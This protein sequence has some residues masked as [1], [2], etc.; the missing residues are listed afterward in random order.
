MFLKSIWTKTGL[1]VLTVPIAMLTNAV[2]IVTIWFLAIHV[3][4][5]FMY[6]TLHR[7]GGILFSLISLF[8]LLFSLWRLR[9]LDYRAGHLT[10]V[11]SSSDD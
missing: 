3:N 8:I 1:S 10:M 6:G 11:R 4:A 7:N 5:D 2:R 9:K